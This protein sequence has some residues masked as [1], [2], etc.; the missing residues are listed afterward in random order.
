MH[1]S[2]VYD[3]IETQNPTE[4]AQKDDKQLLLDIY[5]E[6]KRLIYKIVKGLTDSPELTEEFIQECL[7]RLMP[8]MDIFRTLES[9]SSTSYIATTVRNLGTNHFRRETLKSRYFV[10]ADISAFDDDNFA[11]WQ[12][13]GDRPVEDEA[14]LLVEAEEL[15]TILDQLPERE[16]ILLRG[17][18]HLFLS[19]EELGQEL[20]CAAS[21]IRMML[22]RARKHAQAVLSEKG[23]Q[24]E[25]T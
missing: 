19:D 23:F 2:G 24:Y 3:M 20:N 7:C 12:T 22:T 15:K 17:K 4:S 1:R 16:Q 9:S 14:L 21:S 5:E 11:T 13:G 18:Y 25:N 10:D 6:Y 8:K